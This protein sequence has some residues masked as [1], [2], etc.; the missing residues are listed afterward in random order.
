MK[1]LK[2]KISHFNR[3]LI[4]SIVFLFS[5]LFYLSLPGLYDQEK[6]KKQLEIKLLE[7]YKLSISLS[8]QINY[9]ILPSPN[10]EV[11]DSIL[12]YTKKD[13]NNKFGEIKKIKIFVSARTLYKQEKI[14]LKRIILIKMSYYYSFMIINLFL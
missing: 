5:Y 4:L 1:K 10:F 3:Y 6:L 11:T 2:I 8:D 12:Y 14:K 13:K 7:E 9:R